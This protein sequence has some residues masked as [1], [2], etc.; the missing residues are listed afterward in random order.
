MKIITKVLLVHANGHAQPGEIIEV[1]DADGKSL[2]A[3]G[4]ADTPPEPPADEKA[5]ADD[6]AKPTKSK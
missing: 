2:I 4:K 6:N 1:D 3:A 5:E